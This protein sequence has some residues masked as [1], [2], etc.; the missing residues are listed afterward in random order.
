M[1]KDEE[2]KKLKEKIKVLENKIKKMESAFELQIRNREKRI[3][4]LEKN[5][6]L[7]MGTALKQ[8]EENENLKNKLRKKINQKKG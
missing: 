4:E 1:D 6:D 3:E 2:I 8:S 5:N 7:L